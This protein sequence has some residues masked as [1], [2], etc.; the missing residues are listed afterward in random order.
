MARA[1][2][3]AML[4]EHASPVAC[5][6]GQDAGGQNVYVDQLSRHLGRLG[7]QV[8]VF[9]RRD[10]PSQPE[11]VP[12]ADN[13]RVVSLPVGP[14]YFV[15]KD[16]LWPL[17]PA[18]RDA[19][20]AYM[21]RRGAR[22]DLLHGHFWMSGWVVADLG[23]RLGLPTVQTF[24]ALGVTKR[25][26]QG[27]ADSSP[28]E[29]FLVERRIVAGVDRVIAHCPTELLELSEDYGAARCRLALLPGAV[30]L[31]Q[32]R[33]LPKLQARR[34]LGMHPT[35]PQ[36]VYVGRLLPRKDVRNVV[37]A[38]ALLRQG[39]GLPAE[40]LIVGGETADPDPGATPEIGALQQLA[41]KL[42]VQE[43]VRFAGRKQP[44]ELAVYYAAGDVKVT[45][46]WYEP[47]G[48]TPLEAMACGR[49]VVGSAV[50]GLT[51]SVQDG[52]TGLLVPPRAPQALAASLERLL[53]DP[54]LRECFGRAGRRRVET[55]FGWPLAAQRFAD[56]YQQLVDSA[57]ERHRLPRRQ[58]AAHAGASAGEAVGAL[59]APGAG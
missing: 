27:A 50:G 24:H 45:T 28:P 1:L 12:W 32:F 38:L 5:L 17:M 25:R 34:Q 31:Q 41:A 26:H 11:V 53:R 40:P 13:V 20:L 19:L 37:R 57:S 16:D 10:E 43:A 49:P 4:S 15:P 42:G 23:R 9:T 21:L 18:F 22:Y 3:I 33:P 44:S 7:Y 59:V 55:E 29:R 30:D 47:F 51:F 8:D 46:P 36:I 14:P 35:A 39:S 52:V 56:L 54:S 58:E 48:L 6:G 2:R